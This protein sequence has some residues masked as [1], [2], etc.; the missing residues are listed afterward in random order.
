M[1]ISGEWRRENGGEE[2]AARRKGWER[3]GGEICSACS[4]QVSLRGRGGVKVCGS[5]HA[6]DDKPYLPAL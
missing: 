4:L 1:T 6:A 3:E 2:G 5:K